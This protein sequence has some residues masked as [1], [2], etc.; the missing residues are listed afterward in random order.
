[1]KQ[2][3]DLKQIL[4]CAGLILA[5]VAA[6]IVNAEAHLYNLAPVAALSLFSGAVLKNK[7]YAYLIPLAAYFISDLYF[8][9][10]A[11][12]GFYGI[13][14]FFVYGGMALVALLG[15]RMGQPKALKV[16]GFSIAGSLLFWIISNFGVF[17]GGYWGTGLKGFTTTYLMALPF[18]YQK[19]NYLFHEFPAGRSDLQRRIVWR[20]CFA[21][22]QNQCCK[23]RSTGCTLKNR[24]LNFYNSNQRRL[25]E[26]IVCVILYKRSGARRGF[27]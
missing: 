22:A 19:R 6:R 3:N 9:V 7:S 17:V 16:F 2:N 13:S 18:L 25:F 11:G 5:A 27:H 23:G 10:T 15:T 20:L 26:K 24:N 1:M 21:E 14:Q 4:L 8:Q 12:T